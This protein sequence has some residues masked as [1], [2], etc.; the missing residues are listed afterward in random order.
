MSPLRSSN[1]LLTESGLEPG[2]PQLRFRAHSLGWCIL[3]MALSRGGGHGICLILNRELFCHQTSCPSGLSQCKWLCPPGP[4]KATRCTNQDEEC[5][6]WVTERLPQCQLHGTQEMLSKRTSE[7]GERH[8]GSANLKESRRG[9]GGTQPPSTWQAPALNLRVMG[10]ELRAPSLRQLEPGR[11]RKRARDSG[12]RTKIPWLNR[13]W[14]WR[15]WRNVAPGNRHCFTAARW[16][17][18]TW[19]A[20]LRSGNYSERNLS[21]VNHKFGHIKDRLVAS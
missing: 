6:E 21:L 19:Q 17:Q 20:M 9:C 4:R 13:C 11:E 12:D 15:H 5:E 16:E 18:P 10:N 14:F 2:F 3:G 1:Q 7:A 8:S